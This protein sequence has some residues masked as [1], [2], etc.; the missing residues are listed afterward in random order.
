MVARAKPSA[1]GSIRQSLTSNC[2]EPSPVTSSTL[3][4][5]VTLSSSRPSSACTIMACRLPVAPK[6][7]AMI[8]PIVASLT[9]TSWYLV[10][11]GLV[12]GPR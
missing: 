3:D 6:T 5:D 1:A 11:E 2:P 9:P 8:G 10:R 7:P 12:S 4:G